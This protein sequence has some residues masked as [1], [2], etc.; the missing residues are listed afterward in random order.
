[1]LEK[2]KTYRSAILPVLL[3]VILAGLLLF[4]YVLPDGKLH[5]F[6]F[7]VGQGDG[8]MVI[9]PHGKI[10]V[11]DGGPDSTIL[12]KIGRVKPFL[13]TVD[14]V[15]LTH[16]H[17]DHEVGLIDVFKK[18]RV[19]NIITSGADV[20]TPEHQAFLQAVS[21]ERA[22]TRFFTKGETINLDSVKL[23]TFYPKDSFFGKIIENPNDASLVLKM[24]YGTFSV[25]FSG[26]IEEMARLKLLDGNF[27]LRSDLLK[28][29]HH[30]SKTGLSK[31]LLEKIQADWA[32]ISV[33][34]KNL[35]GHPAAKTLE[36]LANFSIPVLRTD[37]NGDVE[38]IVDNDGSYKIRTQK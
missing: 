31:K 17:A 10:V 25:L 1:M 9:T 34:V 15:I 21:N 11:I 36:L 26:D 29:S 28:V 37:N 33:G 24:F 30:G 16:P 35:Y 6:I 13:K 23:I 3:G 38:F 2:F 14:Y 27:D 32:V 22:D 7:D 12:S 8:M 20:D 4:F 19:L 18:Y 5:V